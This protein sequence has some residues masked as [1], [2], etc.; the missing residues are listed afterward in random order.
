MGITS[1]RIRWA[2]TGTDPAV[3]Y[4]PHPRSRAAA[5]LRR[6]TKRTRRQRAYLPWSDATSKNVRPDDRT[7]SDEVSHPRPRGAAAE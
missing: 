3:L 7:H 4:I 1:Q 6:K 2:T 5:I